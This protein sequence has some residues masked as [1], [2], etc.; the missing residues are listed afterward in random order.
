M[1]NLIYNTR[2]QVEVFLISVIVLITGVLSLGGMD[3]TIIGS[4][5]IALLMIG[6]ILVI[7]ANAIRSR[8]LIMGGYVMLIGALIAFRIDVQLYGAPTWSG[9]L[10]SLALITYYISNIISVRI[11]EHI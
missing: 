1:N 11:G 7:V 2:K 4:A 5:Y 3:L 6:F 9:A 8:G 10:P